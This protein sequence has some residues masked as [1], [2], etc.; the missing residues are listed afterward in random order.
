MQAQKNMGK[1]M[2]K[3]G[4]NIMAICQFTGCSISV[5]NY[6]DRPAGEPVAIL[7]YGED[8]KS[9]S[10]TVRLIARCFD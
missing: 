4:K 8:Q 1:L 2:G 10:E 7:V 9:V 5:P 3:G 6:N